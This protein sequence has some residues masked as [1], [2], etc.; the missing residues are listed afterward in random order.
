MTELLA[1]AGELPADLHVQALRTCGGMALILGEG[2]DG[3]RY[4]EDALA[5]YQRLGD[6]RGVG[7]IEFRLALELRWRGDL[8]GARVRAEESL[9]LVRAA[10]FAKGEAQALTVLG[11]IELAEGNDERGFSMF[12][13]GLALAEQH[14]F[15]WWRIVI[16][17]SLAFRL[18][19][20]G[21]VA[22]AEVYARTAISLSRDIDDR[23]HGVPL[24]ALL[25]CFAVQTNRAARG[26]LLWGAAE[27]DEAR[28]PL[29]GWEDDL[30][31]CIDVLGKA[32]GTDFERGR[33]EGSGFTL[34]EAYQRALSEDE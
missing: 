8:E 17:Y 25:A 27:A 32:S 21:R 23:Q 31:L 30:S 15:T 18:W 6:D 12:E 24:L 1:R 28:T 3:F 14:G 5:E 16:L 9:R 19:E 22:E 20:R 7:I 29:P 26:G 33:A 34:D 10:G 13:H 11:S 2:D 4:Y